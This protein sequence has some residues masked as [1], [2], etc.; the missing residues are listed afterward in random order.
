VLSQTAEGRVVKL[1]DRD[2][3]GRVDENV[4]ILGGLDRP[5]GLAFAGST[6]F[7]AETSRVLRLDVWWDGSS[8]REIIALPGGG[9]HF[10]RSLAVGPDDKLYVSTGA[11]C[12]VCQESDPRRAAVWR[13]N[14]DGSGGEPFAT[15]LR[16]AVGLAWDPTTGALWATDNER[17]EL[18]PDVPPD[19]LDVLRLGADYGWPACYGQRVPMPSFGTVGRCANTE[20]PA[21]E[22]PAHTAPLGLSYADSTRL[23]PS[24]R[25][26]F[27]VALHGEVRQSYPAG[28]TLVFVPMRNGQPGSPVEVVRGWRVGDES[29]GRPVGPLVTREGTLYVTDDT[30]GVIYRLQA[31]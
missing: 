2:G 7:V 17:N 3:D 19:E 13:Y 5:H 25:G 11:S 12:D 4:P 27:F 26:G 15:G 23:P 6:L 16:N 18:G 24:Y 10:T 22:L 30:A 31:R 1:V 20:L 14:L 9:H 29:W 21:L 28:H 8:A